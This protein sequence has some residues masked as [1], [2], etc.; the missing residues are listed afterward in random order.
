MYAYLDRSSTVR[1]VFTI[2]AIAAI[3]LF[4]FWIASFVMNFKD[5]MELS[6][7]HESV[8]IALVSGTGQFF[9]PDG[10]IAQPAWQLVLGKSATPT[11]GLFGNGHWIFATAQTSSIGG[12]VPYSNSCDADPSLS[13][14]DVGAVLR[15]SQ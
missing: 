3:G 13:V 1:L 8:G 12:P 15:Q 4:L 14:N 2:L 11:C 9:P 10:A 6:S 7:L 5:R